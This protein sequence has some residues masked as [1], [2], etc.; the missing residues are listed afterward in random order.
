MEVGIAEGA[1]VVPQLA[2]IQGARGLVGGM[3][4]GGVAGGGGQLVL[5]RLRTR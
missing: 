1:V 2:G 5:L 3:G 4:E